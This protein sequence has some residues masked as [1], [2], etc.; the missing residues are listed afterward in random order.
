MKIW[1]FGNLGMC[2]FENL[3]MWGYGD[4]GM[5]GCENLKMMELRNTFEFLNVEV[6]HLNNRIIEQPNKQLN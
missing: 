5:W 3:G 6:K 2:G 1:G 4:V